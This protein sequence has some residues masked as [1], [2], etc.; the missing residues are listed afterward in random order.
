MTKPL[1]VNRS[2]NPR[3]LKGVNQNY[4]FLRR[5]E[6]AKNLNEENG[7]KSEGDIFQFNRKHVLV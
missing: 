1:L 5:V 2:L 4:R 3:T 6:A 7:S